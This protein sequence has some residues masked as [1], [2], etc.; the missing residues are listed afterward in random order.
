MLIIEIYK[1]DT[2]KCRIELTGRLDTTTSAE[3]DEKF[4]GIDLKAHSLQIVDLAGLNYM[5][6][7]GVRSL[8]KA[9][10]NVQEQGG[11]FM[12]VNP[13]PQI[14][15][16][17]DIIKALPNTAIFVSQSELDE[18]LAVQQKKLQ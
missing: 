15:K 11:Q 17:F 2:S 5:S 1:S 14:K 10:K 9:R 12:I 8:F 3:F 16:V 18:Y 7:A 13:Q 4:A 6:S